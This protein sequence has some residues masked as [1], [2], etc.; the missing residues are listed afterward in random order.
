MVGTDGSATASEAVRRAAVVARARGARL[1]LV[2]AY[3]AR[4]SRAQRDEIQ[5]M[6][7]DLRWRVSPGEGAEEVLRAAVSL[8]AD[9]GLEV[10]SH[11]RPGDPA[12]VLIDVAED[13]GAEL[14]VVG[15]RGMQ[16]V[17]RSLL[18]TVPNR[19]SHRAGCDVLIVHT[20]GNAA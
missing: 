9:A 2:T 14:I 8:V 1:H 17:G 6:P 4:L 3:D 11:A 16:G 10:T 5:R 13:V 19:V 15:N 12:E 7:E 20:T 18:P